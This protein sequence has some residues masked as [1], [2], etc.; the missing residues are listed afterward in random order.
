LLRV[1]A[2]AHTVVMPDLVVIAFGLRPAGCITVTGYA[3][4]R[5]IALPVGFAGLPVGPGYR[6]GWIVVHS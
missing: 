4:E 6:F 1:V 2:L 3:V 5:W